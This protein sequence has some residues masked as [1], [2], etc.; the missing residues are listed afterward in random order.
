MANVLTQNVTVAVDYNPTAAPG[1]A[2]L[3]CVLSLSELKQTRA[4]EKYSCMSSNDEY[5][6]VGSIT[7]D[8]ITLTSTYNE[9]GTD[10]QFI[11]KDAFEN[12]KPVSVKIEFDNSLGTNGT[13][14]EGNGYV[15]SYS[16][17]MEANKLVEVAFEILWDGG[18]LITPAS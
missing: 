13:T 2:D 12:N 1:P 9:D 18:I 7:R 17:S 3:D 4:S 15:S 16:V 5:I 14:I 10:G 11:L 8:P 6:A